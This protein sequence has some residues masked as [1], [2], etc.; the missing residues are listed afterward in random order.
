MIHFSAAANTKPL[1]LRRTPRHLAAGETLYHTGEDGLAWRL[2][3]G[4]VRLDLSGHDGQPAFAS[5]AVAGDILGC[6]TL[7]FGAYTF[8]A[9]ALTEC[10]LSPWPE[11]VSAP[12]TGTLLASLAGAQRRAAELVTLRGGQAVDRVLGLIRL[13]ADGAGQVVL[14]SR[15]D[16]AAITD[17]RCETISRIIK[18]LER[19][20]VLTPIR[21]DGVHATRSFALLP[22]G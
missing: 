18:A 12:A 20:H 15:Q 22:A 5:L 6:E 16:I 17:L 13:L 3:Q 1:R 8:S 19:Q 7:L 14:P 2:E 11:G 9:S 10:H 4:A 21:I